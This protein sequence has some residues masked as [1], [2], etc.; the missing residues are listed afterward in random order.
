MAPSF[1]YDFL[2]KAERSSFLSYCAFGEPPSSFP[3]RRLK[4]AD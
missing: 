2:G 4:V 1:A 3:R